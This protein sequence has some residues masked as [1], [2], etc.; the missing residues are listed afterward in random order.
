MQEHLPL[1]KHALQLN[2][3]PFVEACLTNDLQQVKTFN[4]NIQHTVSREILRYVCKLNLCEMV[5][6][7]VSVGE[8]YQ[9]MITDLFVT[10]CMVGHVDLVKW[11]ESYISISTR[12][13]NMQL[14]LCR[15]IQYGRTRVIEYLK[16]K[17]CF[18]YSKHKIIG[19]FYN[20][21]Q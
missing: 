4:N 6:Y 20:G 16:N 1:I 15:A 9:Y 5:Q 11:L 21:K 13:E 19:C 12:H 2:V 3:D 18:D 8:V 14:G 7:L 10:S 17:S